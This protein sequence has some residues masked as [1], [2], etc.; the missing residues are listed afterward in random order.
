MK[1]GAPTENVAEM[2]LNWG[3]TNAATAGSVGRLVEPAQESADSPSP[4]VAAANVLST[5]TD[6]H[7][8]RSDHGWSTVVGVG[9]VGSGILLAAAGVSRRRPR[10]RRPDL[11]PA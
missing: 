5:P 7:T 11:P 9:L 10:R 3:F 8:A 6:K 4:V 2:L 1:I